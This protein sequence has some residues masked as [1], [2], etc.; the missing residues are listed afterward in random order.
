MKKLKTLLITLY[1][2]WNVFRTKLGDKLIKI[3][4]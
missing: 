1:L 3:G 2:R 4:E